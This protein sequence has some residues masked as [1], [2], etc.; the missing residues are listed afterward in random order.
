MSEVKKVNASSQNKKKK[1]EKDH[2]ADPSYRNKVSRY[3]FFL[4]KV[5]R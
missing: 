2:V 5:P 4:V 3:P 1:N